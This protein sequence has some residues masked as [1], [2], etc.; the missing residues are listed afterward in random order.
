MDI[1]EAMK[2]RHSVRTYTDKKIEGEVLHALHQIIDACNAASGLSIQLCVDEPGAFSG[3]MARYGKFKNVKNYIALVGPKD[4][5]LDEKCGYYGEKL[6]L[7]AQQLGLNTCWVAMTFSKGKSKSAI[8]INP[9]E[10][11]LMVI[12]LGY[13]ETN[14]VAHKTKSIEELSQTSDTIPDWFRS[15]MEA[16][17]LAPTAMNQQKFTFTRKGTSVSA[18]SGSG[19]YTKVDLG[20]AKYHFELGAGDGEWSWMAN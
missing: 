3:M 11:L 17:Q 2:T 9:G 10:K 19:F 12:A 20:I 16:V 8:K 18:A 15:G 4:A 14:G 5:A 6:V 13:G 1:F 7:E